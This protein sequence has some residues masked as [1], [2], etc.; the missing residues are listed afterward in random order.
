MAAH[1]PAVAPAATAVT[2]PTTI[3]HGPYLVPGRRRLA[4]LAGTVLGRRPTHRGRLRGHL[5]RV[6]VVGVA[7][8]IATMAGVEAPAATATTVT[9]GAPEVPAAVGTVDEQR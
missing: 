9:I 4:A 8:A 5:R 3:A 6:V 2:V 7:G 1:P